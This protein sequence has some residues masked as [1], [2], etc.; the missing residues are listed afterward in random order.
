VALALAV[1]TALATAFAAGLDWQAFIECPPSVSGDVVLSGGVP[2][3]TR[4]DTDTVIRTARI[5]TTTNRV[6]LLHHG[7]H[8]LAD[9]RHQDAAPVRL[10]HRAA[11]RGHRPGAEPRAPRRRPAQLRARAATRSSPPRSSATCRSTCRPATTAKHRL[12][13]NIT[14]AASRLKNLTLSALYQDAEGRCAR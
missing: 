10:G 7:R 11:V 4:A 12:Y 5:G 8:R 2:I 3:S 14:G 9:H 13:L 1:D 6:A